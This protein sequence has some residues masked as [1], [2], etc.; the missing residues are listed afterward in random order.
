MFKFHENFFLQNIRYARQTLQQNDTT[1]L[2]SKRRIYI[3]QRKEFYRKPGKQKSQGRTNK[4]YPKIIFTFWKNSS[5]NSGTLPIKKLLLFLHGRETFL[6][7]QSL[8]LYFYT[9]QQPK[10]KKKFKQTNFNT[11]FT[12][13]M[14]I[15]H[16]S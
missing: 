13:H 9:S 7:C 10:K 3:S 5:E 11:D 15:K 2:S 6:L 14:N 16:Y 1:Q 4:D 12:A 8:L